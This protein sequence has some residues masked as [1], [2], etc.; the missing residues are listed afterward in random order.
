M[1]IGDLTSGALFGLVGS[2]G[3]LVGA[4]VGVCISSAVGV[5]YVRLGLM[6]S[7]GSGLPVGI[8]DTDGIGGVNVRLGPSVEEVIITGLVGL[9][10]VGV[11][12]GIG[13]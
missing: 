12:V 11:G 2:S 6:A 13:T 1:P 9:A 8:S 3:F 5:M 10:G 7:L 4:G